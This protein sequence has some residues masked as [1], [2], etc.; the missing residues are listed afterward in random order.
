[1]MVRNGGPVTGCLIHRFIK[2][3][4]HKDVWVRMSGKEVI[5]RIGLSQGFS[6]SV[7][8]YSIRV[9]RT[10]KMSLF[11]MCMMANSNY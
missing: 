5:N 11:S 7:A 10:M 4:G 6:T 1:M 3:R 9:D 8:G 2:Y